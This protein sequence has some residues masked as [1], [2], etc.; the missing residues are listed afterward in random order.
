MNIMW[1][2]ILTVVV[3]LEKLSYKNP[4]LFRRVTGTLLIFWGIAITV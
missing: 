3:L 1:V 2:I 4:L